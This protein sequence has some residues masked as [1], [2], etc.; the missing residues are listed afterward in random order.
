MFWGCEGEG[1]FCW[2]CVGGCFVVGL[3]NGM[4]L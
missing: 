4:S 3:G 1:G 2:G